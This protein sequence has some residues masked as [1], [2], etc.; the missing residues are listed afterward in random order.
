MIG[1]IPEFYQDAR[2][3]EDVFRA[4]LRDVKG[5][6]DIVPKK[7]DPEAEVDD[8]LETYSEGER[9]GMF[10]ITDFRVGQSFE[11]EFE[12]LGQDEVMIRYQDIAFLSGH[13]A[14]LIYKVN[15]DSSVEFKREE[16]RIMS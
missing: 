14:T 12:T 6:V 9:Y 11:D 4:V 2:E 13:G 5:R 1:R 15:P 8:I 3:N 10:T 16:G 7:L